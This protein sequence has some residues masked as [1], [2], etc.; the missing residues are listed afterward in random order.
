MLCFV[1]YVMIVKKDVRWFLDGDEVS[2]LMVITV[3]G[4]VC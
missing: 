1:K 4:G 3:N 2:W